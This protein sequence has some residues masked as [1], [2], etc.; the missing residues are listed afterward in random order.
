M[1]IE[2]L[3]PARLSISVPCSVHLEVWSLDH[4]SPFRRS[5]RLSLPSFL[6]VLPEGGWRIPD[7]EALPINDHRR[8]EHLEGSG[9]RV[10]QFLKDPGAEDVFVGEDVC[11]RVDGSARDAAGTHLLRPLLSGPLAKLF[12]KLC[13]QSFAVGHAVGVGRE[14]PVLGQRGTAYSFAQVGELR[15]VADGHDNG[16]VR[17]MKGLVGDYRRVCVSDQ[18]GVLA[19]YKVLL[20]AV[21]EPAEG[22]LEERDLDACALSGHA[23]PVEGSQD[24]VRREKAAHYV[25]DRDSDLRRLT[26]RLACDAHDTTP[27]LHQEVVARTVLIRPRAEARDGAVDETRVRLS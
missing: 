7:R 6:N 12:L 8:G 11:E 17:S 23:A 5:V 10:V 19:T 25:R 2:M 20:A 1:A 27:G 16:L 4:G 21:G 15:V 22:G 3:A 26:T 14:A 24:R 9:R 18:T 13:D